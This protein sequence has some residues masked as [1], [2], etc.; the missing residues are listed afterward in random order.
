MPSPDMRAV[1]EE[2]LDYLPELPKD[3]TEAP[4]LPTVTDADWQ[5][6]P[7]PVKM[8]KIRAALMNAKTA[9]D[10]EDQARRLPVADW[11]ELVAKLAPKNIQVQADF[12]FKHLVEE[13]GPIDKEKFRRKKEPDA[14]DAEYKAIP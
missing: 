5:N 3:D 8:E 4:S 7:V 10:V 13:F 14:I 9:F 12:S 6:D 2:D 1:L 11:I